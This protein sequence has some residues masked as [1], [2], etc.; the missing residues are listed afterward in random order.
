MRHK[1]KA[2][3]G[4]SRSHS[5]MAGR[6]TLPRSAFSA[7]EQQNSTRASRRIVLH[8]NPCRTCVRLVARELIDAKIEQVGVGNPGTVDIQNEVAMRRRSDRDTGEGLGDAAARNVRVAGQEYAVQ[9]SN[10]FRHLTVVV[11]A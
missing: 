6:V 1:E 8:G 7:P 5:H 4:A 9:P 3:T 2:A 10:D 11:L